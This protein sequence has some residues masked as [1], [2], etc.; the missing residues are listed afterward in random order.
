MNSLEKYATKKHLVQELI[1]QAGLIGKGARW[2][3]QKARPAARWLGKELRPVAQIPRNVRTL[4]RTR[5]AAVH[6]APEGSRAM[7]N[8]TREIKRDLPIKKN[9]NSQNMGGRT[10]SMPPRKE[11]LEMGEKWPIL[12]PKGLNFWS[13]N[14][15][16]GVGAW[17]V[18]KEM[19]RDTRSNAL[20]GLGK[21]YLN[22]LGLAL[23]GGT[24]G[25]LASA[26]SRRAISNR[27][28]PTMSGR[29]PSRTAS[30]S[31]KQW[32]GY[33]AQIG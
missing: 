7:K 10:A 27:A 30:P 2:L 9:W 12:N 29:N 19:I 15:P 28:V 11:R 32:K 31:L 1:K 21:G 22:T 20:S 25:V 24:A 23:G 5:K 16:S 3:G 26:P 33:R 14:N 13:P 6:R 8:V 18:R 17:G 4:W